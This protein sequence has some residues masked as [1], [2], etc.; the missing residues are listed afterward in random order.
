MTSGGDW[1]ID[2]TIVLNDIF[3]SQS[4]FDTTPIVDQKGFARHQSRFLK[5]VHLVLDSFIGAGITCGFVHFANG[6]EHKAR[7]RINGGYRLDSCPAG[8]WLLIAESPERPTYWIPQAPILRSFDE[9]GHILSEKPAAIVGIQLMVDSITI[10]VGI[11]NRLAL[12]LVV[13]HLLPGNARW[14]SELTDLSAIEE[15]PYFLW[16]SHTLYRRPADVYLHLIQGEVYENRLSWPHRWKIHSENDAHALYVTLCGLGRATGK[17]LYRLL[18]TQLL[19]SVIARQG[20]D[21]GWRHG[22]W[23]RHMESHCRLHCS[24]MHMLMDALAESNDQ[25]AR[26]ALERAAAFIA[27]QTDTLAIGTWFLHDELEH[28]TALLDQGPF[29]WVSSRALGKSETNMLVL[30]THLD[31]IIALDRYRELTRDNRY[32]SA[33]NSA[34][35]AAAAVMAL[36]PVEWLYR[37]LF[38]A[39]GLTHLPTAQAKRLPLPIRAIKR[40]TW[41]CLIRWLPAIKARFPRLVMPGGYIDR[42]LVVKNW[43]HAYQSINLMDLMRYSRRFPQPNLAGVIEEGFDFTQTSG[44]R[45]RWRELPEKCYALGFWAEALYHRCM[46]IQAPKYRAWL[47]EAML[48]LTDLGLGMP[49]SLLGAN[50]EAVSPSNQAPCPYPTDKRLLVANLSQA[51]WLE[52]VVVNPTDET[53]P[54]VCEGVE[55]DRFSWRNDRGQLLDQA[56]GLVIPGRGW[57][58]GSCN[59]RTA[60]VARCAS[61]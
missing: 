17:Q 41:K 55:K 50:A 57:L 46:L 2:T 27:R 7:I 30:N 21:G 4:T 52:M 61:A 3:E 39:I 40:L 31:A 6:G 35:D 45:S 60:E 51:D 48:D 59:R 15:Q 11:G 9:Q 28:S 10:E 13:W 22:E 8:G 37:L 25:S 53:I 56:A 38:K 12:D 34:C 32:A 33:V 54:F 5:N 19:Y 18:K 58:G 14:I 24:A 20:E 47:A 1:P 49:P 44:I 26:A 42:A 36:R 29:R 16:G 43:S 23:T